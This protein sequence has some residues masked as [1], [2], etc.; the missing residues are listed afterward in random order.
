MIFKVQFKCYFLHE[1]F[2]SNKCDSNSSQS[3]TLTSITRE[4]L[5]PLKLTDQGRSSWLAGSFLPWDAFRNPGSC[6]LVVLWNPLLPA[7]K[8]RKGRS[9]TYF[10]KSPAWKCLTLHWQ[11]H[12]CVHFWVQRGNVTPGFALWNREHTFLMDS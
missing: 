6:C 5:F 11:E 9:H 7:N 10:L 4:L 2:H 3:Q 1:I 12:S 8:G